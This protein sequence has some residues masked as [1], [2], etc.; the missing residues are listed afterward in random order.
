MYLRD[1]KRS[2]KALERQLWVK[3]SRRTS[4]WQ[5]HLSCLPLALSHWYSGILYWAPS[6]RLPTYN[7]F[8]FF[9]FALLLPPSLHRRGLYGFGDKPDLLFLPFSFLY[10][11]L[12]C[13]FLLFLPH[14][15][16]FPSFDHRVLQLPLPHSFFSPIHFS[17]TRPF[18]PILP[19][20]SS[21]F[22]S[23]RVFIFLSSSRP[24]SSPHLQ[25]IFFPPWQIL[26]SSPPPTPFGISSY[27]RFPPR[28]QIATY[29]FFISV[30]LQL[31]EVK[32]EG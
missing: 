3:A 22:A 11:M 25:N 30:F 10:L 17:S 29:P 1:R 12:F 5:N 4:Y 24:F 18:I 15:A 26:P 6:S 16:L 20:Q 23:I 27:P 31:S 8:F 9:F 2:V 7:L 14:F 28:R 13:H 19:P 21:C 32:L